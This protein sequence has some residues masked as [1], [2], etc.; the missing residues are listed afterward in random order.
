MQIVLFQPEIPPNTGNIARLC[1]AT[2]VRLNLIEP[3]GFKL[4]D[5]YLKR[6]GLDYWPLVDMRV[7]PSLEDWIAANAGVRIVPASAKGG[8]PAHRFPFLPDDA[9]LFGRETSGLPASAYTMTPYRVR[10]PFASDVSRESGTPCVR[11][12]NLSTAVGIVLYFALQHAGI[13]D[14]WVS[15]QPVF[16]TR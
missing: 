1:A 11:S 15:E 13:L 16:G 2:K 4:E 12:L 8:A 10:L 6:A 14:T 5:R 7:W 3:L 9:L